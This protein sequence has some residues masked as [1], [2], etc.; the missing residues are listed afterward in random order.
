MGSPPGKIV[1]IYRLSLL[2]HKD[3]IAGMARLEDASERAV[4]Q[5]IEPPA[6]LPAS[7]KEGRWTCG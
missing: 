4:D 1:D 3:V 6:F 7:G 5:A 2:N